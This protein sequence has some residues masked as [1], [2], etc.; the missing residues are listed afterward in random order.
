MDQ[1]RFNKLAKDMVKESEPFGFLSYSDWMETLPSF[2]AFLKEGKSINSLI[3]EALRKEYDRPNSLIW[4]WITLLNIINPEAAKEI[5]TD[6]IRG[7]L[8]HMQ[9][10]WVKWGK[11]NGIKYSN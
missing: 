2:Q 6:K 3:L 11:K 1:A 7:R 5:I 4:H 10:A 8:Y 9:K